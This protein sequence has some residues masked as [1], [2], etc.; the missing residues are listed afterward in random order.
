[1]TVHASSMGSSL[2]DDVPSSSAS[3]SS[4]GVNTSQSFSDVPSPRGVASSR[5]NVQRPS[6]GRGLRK[7]VY[8]DF[9]QV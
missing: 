6:R 4:E 5:S 2:Q 3:L 9:G 7:F 8:F 1:M